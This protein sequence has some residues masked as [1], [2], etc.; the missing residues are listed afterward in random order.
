MIVGFT[1][2]NFNGH[3]A[4]AIKY[5]QRVCILESPDIA[6]NIVA[7]GTGV[8]IF[9]T[10]ITVKELEL[11]PFES[12]PI[13]VE[14]GKYILVSTVNFSLELLYNSRVLRLAPT[15][16]IYIEPDEVVQFSSYIK[17]GFVRTIPEMVKDERVWILDKGYWNDTGI[18]IDINFWKD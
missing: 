13:E 17:Q 5:I 11:Q 9:S 15:E 18:W 10:V 12:S 2:N 1:I 7:T 4:E 8:N 3:E 6:T 14:D 16:F